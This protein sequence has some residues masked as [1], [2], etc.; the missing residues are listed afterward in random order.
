MAKRTVC[1]SHRCDLNGA[2][3]VSALSSFEDYVI[4]DKEDRMVKELSLV[5]L[6]FFPA[7]KTTLSAR[8]SLRTS[9]HYMYHQ[10]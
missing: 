10:V 1:W 8:M 4:S 6:L 2:V 7:A 5:H 9:G 3:S